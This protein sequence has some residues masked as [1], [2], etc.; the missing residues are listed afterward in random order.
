MALGT[1]ALARAGINYLLRIS[2]RWQRAGAFFFN[3]RCKAMAAGSAPEAAVAAVRERGS[4]L[5]STHE[6]QA[7]YSPLVGGE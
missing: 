7:R 4:G 6:R 2:A 1:R 5:H 3:P